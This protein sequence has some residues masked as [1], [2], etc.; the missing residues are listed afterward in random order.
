MI[1]PKGKYQPLR[2]VGTHRT[3]WCAACRNSPKTGKI[4]YINLK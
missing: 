2:N 1:A 4:G 3:Y